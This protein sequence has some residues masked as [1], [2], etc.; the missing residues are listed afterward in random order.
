MCQRVV[1]DDALV[2]GRCAEGVEAVGVSVI[3]YILA[4]IQ[5]EGVWADFSHR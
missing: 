1:F 3:L 5:G 2:E 4:D